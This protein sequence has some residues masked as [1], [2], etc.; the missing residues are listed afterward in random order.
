M[1][2][3]GVDLVPATHF[4]DQPLTAFHGW[5]DPVDAATVTRWRALA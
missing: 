1:T 3:D 2:R 5:A 4:P